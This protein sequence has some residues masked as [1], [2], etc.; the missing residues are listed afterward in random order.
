MTEAGQQ[1]VFKWNKIFNEGKTS[2]G[3]DKR[4]RWPVEGRPALVER[5]G[6]LM[7]MDY[8]RDCWGDHMKRWSAF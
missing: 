1:F 5:V 8:T 2:V 3:D 7:T 6:M 4:S